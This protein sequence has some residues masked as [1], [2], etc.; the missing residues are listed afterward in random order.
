MNAAIARGRNNLISISRNS[1]SDALVKG[2]LFGA[3]LEYYAG[4]VNEV[5]IF[6]GLKDDGGRA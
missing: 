1:V 4:R 2:E 6:K 5:F 3:F